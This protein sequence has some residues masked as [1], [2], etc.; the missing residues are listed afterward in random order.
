MKIK[1]KQMQII[2]YGYEFIELEAEK[3]GNI[4]SEMEDFGFSKRFMKRSYLNGLIEINGKKVKRAFKIKKKDRI[5]IYYREENPD[6]EP[7]DGDFDIIFE[8]ENYIIVNKKPFEIVHPTVSH[9]TGTLLN[10]IQ[11]YFIK[12]GIKRKVR[13]VN[14][15][16][17]NTS[18]ILIVAK[19]S[20]LHQQI[21]YQMEK[22]LTIKK[23]YA[24]VENIPKENKGVIEKRISIEK[25]EKMRRFI[26]DEGQYAKTEYKVLKSKNNLSL[27]EV[28]LYT[29]RTHQIRIHM[30]YID[31][32][33]LGDDLYGNET[34][35]I[36]R[37]ALHSYYF[38]FYDP[39]LKKYVEFKSEMPEDM[40]KLM[41]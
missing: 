36:N 17:M 16:D 30:K 28:R 8:N 1:G 19:N 21:A 9:P 15:L 12:N 26:T 10:K 7:S 39:Y 29:G 33:I 20:F 40:N 18:G 24:I 37:Q 27:L 3:D 2:D 41:K 35:L 25:D 13:L 31:C 11:N 4:Y 38:S 22:N 32:P 6:Y 5:K 34:K 14:R 23:Y